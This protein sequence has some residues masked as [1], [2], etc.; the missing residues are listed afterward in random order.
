MFLSYIFIAGIVAIGS[1]TGSKILITQ[2]ETVF[3]SKRDN[4]GIILLDQGNGQF[5]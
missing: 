2:T 1:I 5:K 4:H 3:N